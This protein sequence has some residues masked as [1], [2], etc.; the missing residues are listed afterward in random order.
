[1]LLIPKA[2]GALV[3]LALFGLMLVGLFY[4]PA[5]IGALLGR[6]VGGSVRECRHLF[7]A[8]HRRWSCDA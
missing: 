2:A 4:L 5:A 8:L 6:L 7:R 1:L 3:T